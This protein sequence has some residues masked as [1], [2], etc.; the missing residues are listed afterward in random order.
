MFEKRD[1]FVDVAF[2]WAKDLNEVFGYNL[3]TLLMSR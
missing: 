3:K 2:D 1:D